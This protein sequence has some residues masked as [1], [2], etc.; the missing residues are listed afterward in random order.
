LDISPD[1]KWLAFWQDQHS[2]IVMPSMG[3]ET[4]QV[5]SLVQGVVPAQ[6]G[7]LMWMPDGEHLMYVLCGD[8][9]RLWKVHVETGRQQPLGPPIQN[10]IDASIHPDGKQIAFSV[11][12]T[13][14][15]L[16]IMKGVLPD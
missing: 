8:Q 4:R 1:G 6:V 10:L 11:E 14:S 9:G 2:I 15:E 13:G 16:W 7:H 5:L 12:E 3:G